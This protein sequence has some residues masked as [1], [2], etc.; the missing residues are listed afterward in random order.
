MADGGPATENVLARKV[1]GP[2]MR[3]AG[4]PPMDALCHTFAS[5]AATRVRA[6]LRPGIDVSVYGFE[7]A[8]HGDYLRNLFAPSAIY[9]LGFPGKLGMAL[10]KAH[11]RLLGK[12]LDI[13][14]G[15]D[16]SFEESNFQRSLTAI[17]LSI[18]GRFVDIVAR[19]FDD[20]VRE[21]CTRSAIG[22]A[23]R[24]R[25]EQQPGMVRIAPD[26]AEVFI[27]KLNFH[28]NEDKRGAGLDFVVPVSV[29]ENLKRD[30]IAAQGAG[31][32]SMRGAWAR[33]M[34][35]EVIESR[36]PL[37]AI[38]PAGTH[39]VGRLARLTHGDLL[40][41]PAHALGKIELRVET[42]AGPTCVAC[43]KL[44][45][46]DWSK[47][48]RLETDPDESFLEPLMRRRAALGGD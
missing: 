25:F 17:D 34:M 42:A 8:R 37:R 22:V 9:L 3:L 30:L 36:L 43:G 5:I 7:V 32:D 45:A 46:V 12:V 44:G 15:G 40:E 20:A 35:T 33:H 6:E 21:H 24:T 19:C 38:I 11:P 31:S 13:Y 47:A 23:S 18:Y 14:L 48:V 1:R 16:G 26:Q 39:T 2:K 41:L 29:L 4:F 27:I 10:T 28:M